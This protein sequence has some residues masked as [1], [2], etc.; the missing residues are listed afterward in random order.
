MKFKNYKAAIHNFA[1]SFQSVDYTKSGKLAINVVVH[2]HNHNIVSSATFDFINKTIEP[3]EAVSIESRKLLNDYLHWLPTHFKNHN[4]D[5]EKLEELRLTISAD[6]D[7]AFEPQGMN[8]CKQITVKTRTLWKADGK[9]KQIIDI[10]QE[11]LIDNNFL[12][13]GIPEL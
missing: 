1:H 10:S 11:E 7:K 5:L 13:I 9:D 3:T 2:L 12:K 8:Y 6:F 4:C